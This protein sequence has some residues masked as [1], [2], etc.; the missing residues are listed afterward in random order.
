MTDRFRLQSL[1]DAHRWQF[2]KTMPQWPHEYSM[3][4]WD[5]EESEFREL[6][7]AIHA[8]GVK[9]RFRHFRPNTYFYLNGWR[10][11]FMNADPFKTDCINR[12]DP[13]HPKVQGHIVRLE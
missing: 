1:I 13:H 10:Y 7:Q 3:R 12:C 8:L 2:A 11:W 4:F 6:T 5:W 9:E